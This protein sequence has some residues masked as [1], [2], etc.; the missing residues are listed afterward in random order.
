MHTVRHRWFNYPNGS[1][2][3]A[4]FGSIWT[5]V[6]TVGRAAD[7]PPWNAPT[8]RTSLVRPSCFPQRHP[9]VPL[10][11]VAAKNQY[12]LTGWRGILLPYAVTLTQQQRF[13][14][15]STMISSRPDSSPAQCGRW[16]HLAEGGL[17]DFGSRVILP[18]SRPHRHHDVICL[19][20]IAL[21]RV[22]RDTLHGHILTT[23][24]W[25]L[26]MPT[27][28]VNGHRRLHA[29]QPHGARHPRRR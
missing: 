9:V 12:R 3:T 22:F 13:I 24:N 5:P 16:R 2:H 1:T 18:S 27:G 14:G 4:F 21:A 20:W 25:R 15:C 6:I 19:R 8:G 28:L 29:L 10:R 11:E 7:P 23:G 26:G 17:R